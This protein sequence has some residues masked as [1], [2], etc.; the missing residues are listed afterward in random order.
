MSLDAIASPASAALWLAHA[1]R[2]PGD[3]PIA[4]PHGAPPE[5]PRVAKPHKKRTGRKAKYH[6][7][8]A[9]SLR[10]VRVVPAPVVAPA[11]VA[12]V[13]PE[14][15]RVDVPVTRLRARTTSVKRLA[16]RELE[17]GRQE[18]PPS[19]NAAIPRPRTWGECEERGLGA[20][21]PCPYVGCKHHLAVDVSARCGS[22]KEAYP[23]LDVDQL[24]ATCSLR[25]AAEGEHTLEAVGQLANITRE[26]ARQIEAKAL[27]K[28]ARSPGGKAL[29]EYLEGRRG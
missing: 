9:R 14:A 24:P 19:I 21:V 12:Q 4:D 25:V 16:K 11:P 29:V 28:L 17:Q 22:I 23:G 15:E 5:P 13:V 1:V 20:W 8:H 2:R 6:A 3:A 27:K 26:R 18:Y 10:A 7:K